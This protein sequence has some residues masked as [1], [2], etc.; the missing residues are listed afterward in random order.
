MRVIGSPRIVRSG[1]N[2]RQRAMEFYEPRERLFIRRPSNLNR[3]N[4]NMNINLA[5]LTPV[6]VRPTPEQI[7]T[8]TENITYENISNT[9][10][11]RCPIS[12]TT[13]QNSDEIM[14]IL[15]CGHI[16][17]RENLQRWFQRNV[18][19]PL[20]RYDIREYDPRREI[21]N[22]YNTD[23][24]N[25][26]IP[27]PSPRQRSNSADADLGTQNSSDEDSDSPITANVNN[28]QPVLDIT[29]TLDLSGVLTGDGTPTIDS[30]VNSVVSEITNTLSMEVT[31]YLQSSLDLS[32]IDPQALNDISFNFATIT[33][34]IVQP[35]DS[36]DE[37]SN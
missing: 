37:S 29:R 18:R 23:V 2:G 20:C 8:A 16:F 19:C 1:I 35:E 30:L 36:S 15:H 13:F 4:G 17:L 22:P 12:L 9:T 3:H 5:S 33:Q 6:I 7:S 10:Q 24:T 14:R 21:S 32:N 25:A 26:N 31:N 28:N 11:T 34:A 27:T